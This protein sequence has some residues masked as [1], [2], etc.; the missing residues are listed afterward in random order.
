MKFK[1]SNY[2]LLVVI[3]LF[4]VTN[5]VAQQLSG[6]IRG[7]ISS[8]T[9]QI[10]GSPYEKL[11]RDTYKK[12]TNYNQAVQVRKRDFDGVT[13]D[14]KQILQIDLKNFHSGPILE[15]LNK[16]YA[17]LVT[18]PTGD[19]VAISRATYS[20]NKGPEEVTFEAEWS[21][22]QYASGF[23]PDWTISTAFQF[24][25]AKYV[26]VGTY[27]SYSATVSL[28]GKT[29]TYTAVVLFH[30]NGQSSNLS[31]PEFWDAI[32]DDMNV[33]WKEGR[34]AYQS[35]PENELSLM[36]NASAESEA[37]YTSSLASNA[38]QS[39]G[40]NS[41][42]RLAPQ[43][44]VS[45]QEFWLSTDE[46]EHASGEHGG[47]AVF[48][49]TCSPQPD[50]RQKCEV[51]VNNFAPIETGVLDTIFDIWFHKG[52]KDKKVDTS[53]GPAGTNISC[54]S[55]AGV[56]FSSC[57]IGT[58]CQVNI[59]IGLSVVLGSVSA[60]VTGGNL[61]HDGKA[62][63]NTCNLP[64][65]LAGGT[66]TTPGWDGS[67]PPGSTPNGSGLC[68]FSGSCGSLTFINKC[69]MYGGDYDFLS[70][71]CSGC[72]VCGGSPIVIDVN[73]DGIA[74]SGPANGV[75][76]DLN[77][78][79]TRDRLG[80]T[81]ANSDDAWLALDR[82]GNGSID[83]GSELFGDYTPQPAGPDKNGF[84]ALAEFDRPA[85]GGNGDGLITSQDSIFENLRLWQDTNHNGLADAGELHTLESLNVQAFELTFKESKNTDQFGNEFRYRAK[86][87]DTRNGSVGRWAWDVFLSHP[88]EIVTH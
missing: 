3:S 5:V 75:N 64:P 14:T 35:R 58:S 20:V 6:K 1:H 11:I 76:F 65:T 22:G 36:A 34:P 82:N 68:C 39:P 17:D 21:K 7:E 46:T 10:A 87:R 52:I 47:T 4:V 41:S 86:V 2:L 51:L 43:S 61:W 26:D 18:L 59:Q 19:I 38:Y 69:Y 57:L 77:G 8:G 80:W 81:L 31:S 48:Q 78:N 62:V 63:T 66:C 83:N 24:E 9:N 32:V 25:P 70:C 73:G 29:R 28:L 16:R 67:C 88:E 50:N 33:V 12:L 85:N 42:D 44:N 56:A 53:F 79:G 23:D 74:L 54:S 37:T 84:L 71:T 13:V 15:I 30:N 45:E 55:A 27:T 72:D 49:T 40:P 60:T